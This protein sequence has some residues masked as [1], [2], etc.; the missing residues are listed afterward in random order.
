MLF[1]VLYAT[2]LSICNLRIC[3]SRFR[4]SSTSECIADQLTCGSSGG[5]CSGEFGYISI[6][7]PNLVSDK[8]NTFD[9][10]GSCVTPINIPSSDIESALNTPRTHI[11]K[12]KL[13]KKLF[14]LERRNKRLVVKNIS[15]KNI[16]SQLKKNEFGNTAENTALNEF[17]DDVVLAL[18]R[19]KS[20]DGRSIMKFTPAIKKF[21]LTLNYY[22]P[23]GYKYVRRQLLSSLPHPSTLSKWYQSIDEKPGFTEEAFAALKLKYSNSDKRLACLIVDEMGI[24]QQKIFNGQTVDGLVTF[25]PSD[26]MATQVYVLMLVALNDAFKLPLGYFFVNGLAAEQRANI[27]K[28]CLE[29]CHGVGA[30]VVSLTFDGCAS[31]IATAKMMGCNFEDTNNLKFFLTIHLPETQ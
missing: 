21:A 16:L 19:K 23:A 7:I 5:R 18:Q 3:N 30:E 9:E 29:K 4:A 20:K 27:L 17:S 24:R 8:V 22:S 10:R 2:L 26:E 6:Y 15:L 28:M 11:L 25:G 14:C 12:H 13:E 1:I 31:N